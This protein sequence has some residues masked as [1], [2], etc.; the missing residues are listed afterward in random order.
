[1]NQGFT[2]YN[3]NT[4]KVNSKLKIFSIFKMIMSI[5]YFI[6]AYFI[7][8]FGLIINLILLLIGGGGSKITDTSGVIVG[9]KYISFF[10]II[11][12]I[13]ALVLFIITLIFTIKLFKNKYNKIIDILINILFILINI[14]LIILS[15]KLSF[16]L[17]DFILLVFSIILILNILHIIKISN[18]K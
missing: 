2:N 6:P 13:L 15:F 4:N 18:S 10:T 8:G 3:T 9:I 14:F 1:M 17:F 11:P 12:T 7:F 16:Y 5:I